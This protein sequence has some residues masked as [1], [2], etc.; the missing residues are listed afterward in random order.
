MTKILPKVA[1]ALYLSSLA[2]PCVLDDDYPTDNFIFGIEILLEGW[3]GI[4]AGE[5]HWY[6]NLPF[7]YVIYR[8]WNDRQIPARGVFSALLLLPAVTVLFPVVDTSYGI[9]TVSPY[10]SRAKEVL[11][12]TYIWSACMFLGAIVCWVAPQS[13]R[14]TNVP[15]EP[16]SSQNST[17]AKARTRSILT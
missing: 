9:V 17:S 12:G 1:L 6:A 15:S 3:L 5:L 16:V 4:I 13:P 7:F 2:S 10:L 8:A 14:Y 11:F